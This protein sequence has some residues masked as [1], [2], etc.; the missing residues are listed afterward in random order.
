M[1]AVV[2]PAVGGW[3]VDR[4]RFAGGRS[5]D[6]RHRLRADHLRRGELSARQSP[7][8]GVGTRR[9]RRHRGVPALERF[10]VQPPNRTPLRPVR[11][12][13]LD[14][15]G[16][17]PP[18]RRA[19]APAVGRGLHLLS[20]ADPLAGRGP[21]RHRRPAAVAATHPTAGRPL[22]TRCR[23]WHRLVLAPHGGADAQLY[24]LQYLDRARRRGGTVPVRGAEP[25]GGCI[26]R[27]GDS[28]RRAGRV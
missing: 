11:T 26:P 24:S 12:P 1:A 18:A 16:G 19:D 17:L 6:Q 21:D 22:K 3:W 27:V 13:R 8:A 10:S 23:I 14:R 4:L 28:P 5:V 25:S 9:H 20:R 7:V 15:V 2:P